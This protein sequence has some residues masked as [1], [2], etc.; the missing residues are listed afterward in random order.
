VTR[1][2]AR[3]PSAAADDAT[4]ARAAGTGDQ[5]ALAAIYDR[6]GARL[7]GLCRSLLRDPADAEDCLQEL[8]I[9]A[10]TRLRELREP[11]ALRGWLFAVARSEC[12]ARLDAHKRESVVQDL[13]ARRTSSDDSD[14]DDDVPTAL[15]DSELGA[16]VDDDSE[17]V[18]DR[19][20]LLLE[21][22]DRQGLSVDE[23]AD[24]I[25]VPPATAQSL[26]VHARANAYRWQG[27]LLVAQTGRPLCPQ[28][29]ELLRR[30][31]GALTPRAARQINR[32]IDGCAA[33]FAQRERVATPLAL[34]GAGQA[35]APEAAAAIR[36]PILRTAAHAA[37]LSLK[38]GAA[39]AATSAGGRSSWVAG[40][41]AADPQLSGADR[42]ARRWG[43]PITV[44]A[45]VVVA[46]AIIVGFIL[47]SSGGAPH[48]KSS[49]FV[50][51]P[52]SGASDSGAPATAVGVLIAPSA[53]SVSVTPTRSVT[54][55]KPTK[56][57]TR[58]TPASPSHAPS[59]SKAPQQV[60]LRLTTDLDAASVS[61]SSGSGQ[62]PRR[63][64]CAYV[65][66]AQSTVT[67]STAGVRFRVTVDTFSAPASC[68]N[69]PNTCTF[70]ITA[71]LHVTLTTRAGNGGP[72]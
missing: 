12:L 16:L 41:P 8:F 32:H 48:H 51:P 15:F 28:L 2:P 14:D 3:N 56:T 20:R 24:A 50:I 63:T 39:A 25:G 4:L 17:G 47:G 22:A 21:L 38:A 13:L 57:T 55:T 9:I 18:S 40:W 35:N 58:S 49:G 52:T 61:T 37:A 29:D 34:L 43:A 69:V 23:M 6:Y 7:L 36:G 5:R 42:G 54:P 31:D 60:Q 66:A 65:V 62:C 70:V 68:R 71:S 10:A 67:I 72:Q 1:P 26:V 19:D 45:V 64:T 11:A 59:T 44:L 46:V 30:W 27:A 33:C 53:S